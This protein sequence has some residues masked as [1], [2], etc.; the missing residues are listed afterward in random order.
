MPLS[1]RSLVA[2]VYFDIFMAVQGYYEHKMTDND[3][4]GDV[5]EVPEPW[6]KLGY[7]QP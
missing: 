6:P 2:P 7:R 1:A 4:A 5:P 3:Y